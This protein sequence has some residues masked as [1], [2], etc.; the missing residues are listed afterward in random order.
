MSVGNFG[1]LFLTFF[2]SM[3][4]PVLYKRNG[5][6]AI[7]YLRIDCSP[8]D[9]Y[10]KIQLTDVYNFASYFESNTREELIDYTFDLNKLT[11][12][13]KGAVPKIYENMYTLV[14]KLKP[15]L[16]EDFKCTLNE[17]ALLLINGSFKYLFPLQSMPD[18]DN[19]LYI[20]EIYTNLEK[21]SIYEHL[22]IENLTNHIHTKNQILEK[23][24]REYHN[25]V[26]YSRNEKFDILKSKHIKD[27]FIN[28]QIMKFLVSKPE[29]IVE[30]SSKISGIDSKCLFTTGTQSIWNKI[31]SEPRKEPELIIPEFGK[32]DRKEDLNGPSNPTSKRKLQGLLR[33]IKRSKIQ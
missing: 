9:N 22:L 17:D 28:K 16:S 26:S 3:I 18:S 27:L 6:I 8:H 13:D 7:F 15:V 1:Y 10:I 31:E 33:R 20:K 14:E 5:K 23:I 2:I 11:K 24:A 30:E 19:L 29:E 12:F 25:K 21:L 32:T 4:Q